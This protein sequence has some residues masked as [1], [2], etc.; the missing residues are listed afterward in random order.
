MFEKLDEDEVSQKSLLKVRHSRAM[1]WGP[2]WGPKEPP[3]P[4]LFFPSCRPEAGNSFQK[5]LFGGVFQGLCLWSLCVVQMI[6][7]QWLP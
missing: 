7:M 5:K 3:Y 4:R 2:S 6:S 1:W